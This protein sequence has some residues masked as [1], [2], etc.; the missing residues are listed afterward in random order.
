LVAFCIIL[1]ELKKGWLK[2]GRRSYSSLRDI[3]FLFKK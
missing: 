3:G 2:R 1:Q